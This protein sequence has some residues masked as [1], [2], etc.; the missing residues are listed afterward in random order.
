MYY[1]EIY[2]FVFVKV[3]HVTLFDNC[4]CLIMYSAKANIFKLIIESNNLKEILL[5]RIACICNQ[6]LKLY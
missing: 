3:A 5:R 4:N 2:F 6:K 1:D